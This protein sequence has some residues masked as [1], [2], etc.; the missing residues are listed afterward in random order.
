MLE[1]QVSS[2]FQFGRLDMCT[3]EWIISVIDCPASDPFELLATSR[4]ID[5]YDEYSTLEREYLINYMDNKPTIND[6]ILGVL[7]Q[8]E[9]MGLQCQLW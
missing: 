2:D 4:I 6:T 7:S 3:S 1:M 9:D 5:L 8:K